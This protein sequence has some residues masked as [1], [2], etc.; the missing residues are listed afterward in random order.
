WRVMDGVV[1][2]LRCLDIT[3]ELSNEFRSEDS[4]EITF[5][6]DGS[7]FVWDNLLPCD[8][9]LIRNE[10]TRI[11]DGYGVGGF[12]PAEAIRFWPRSGVNIL[13]D[14]CVFTYGQKEN[15]DGY[16]HGT[17]AQANTWARARLGESK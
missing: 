1:L 4:Y 16:W 12:I 7:V 6:T 3:E 9:K 2:H 5:Y 14:V 10:V 13:T 15:T 8:G 11:K 17:Y